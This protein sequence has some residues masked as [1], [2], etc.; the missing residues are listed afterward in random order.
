[1]AVSV[2]INSLNNWLLAHIKCVAMTSDNRYVMAGTDDSSIHIYDLQSP[3]AEPYVFENVH[4]RK[5]LMSFKL[6][7]ITRLCQCSCHLSG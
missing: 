2:S 5:K 1:M 6:I 3:Q 7:L 4:R